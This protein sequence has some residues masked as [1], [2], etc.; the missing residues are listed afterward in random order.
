MGGGSNPVIEIL[1]PDI[2][3]AESSENHFIPHGKHE[4]TWKL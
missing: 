2:N 3:S 1:T 4:I